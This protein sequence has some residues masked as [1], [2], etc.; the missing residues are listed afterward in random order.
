M[1]EFR[2]PLTSRNQISSGVKLKKSLGMKSNENLIIKDNSSSPSSRVTSTF[3]KSKGQDKIKAQK[4]DRKMFKN[5]YSSKI[6]TSPV[7]TQA[8]PAKKESLH[9]GSKSY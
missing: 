7:K 1:R 5:A 4:P 6:G 9:K 8:T 2:H 3:N